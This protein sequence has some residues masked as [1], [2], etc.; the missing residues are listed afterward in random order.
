MRRTGWIFSRLK[1][2]ENITEVT[3]RQDAPPDKAEEP[4]KA[5][6][7]QLKLELKKVDELVDEPDSLV[8]VKRL[9]E[10]RDDAVTAINTN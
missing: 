9:D 6:E 4:A 5:G 7:Q 8:N 2:L 10:L 1:K 3:E